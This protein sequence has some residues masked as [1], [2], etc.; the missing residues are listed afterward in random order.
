LFSIVAQKAVAQNQPIQPK[1]QGIG[2]ALSLSDIL[3]KQIS[4]ITYNMINTTPIELSQK[5][6]LKDILS[7]D[8]TIGDSLVAMAVAT[9]TMESVY[10]HPKIVTERLKGYELINIQNITVSS[11]NLIRYDLRNKKGRTIYGTNFSIG[12]K[13]EG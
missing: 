3:P 12:A 4:G 5:N 13:M 6:N 9:K 11:V 8:Y 7:F 1:S 2:T 10:D